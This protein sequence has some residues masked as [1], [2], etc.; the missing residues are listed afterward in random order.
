MQKAEEAKAWALSRVGCPYIYGATGQICTPAYREARAAQ[1]PDYAAKIRKN[2]PRLSGS[3]SA[4]T[5]C[6]WRDPDTGTGKRAYDCAQLTRW[7]MDAVGIPLVSGANSQWTK[8]EWAQKGEIAGMPRDLLCLVYRDDG[9]RMGHT[10][11]YLGDGTVIHAKGHDYGVVRQKLAETAFTHY[12]IPQGLYSEISGEQEAVGVLL[13]K[14]NKGDTVKKLQ[15]MLLKAG[16]LLPKYGADGSFG[17]ETLA[18]VMDFQAMRG[19]E[20]TG[21]CDQATWDTLLAA[22]AE[23]APGAGA[24]QPGNVQIQRIKLQ[25]M[26]ACLQDCLSIIKKT[27]EQ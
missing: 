13:K 4:C 6:R 10:G 5:A 25:E 12:G 7:C 8:T 23:Q 22:C 21:V 15:Q 18:A 17:N 9:G 27:L 1:Y 14:G 3:A 2:C 26:Q 19:L 16:M 24:V 20:E 11:I